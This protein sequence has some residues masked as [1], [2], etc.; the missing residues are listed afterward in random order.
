MTVHKL[1]LRNPKKEKVSFWKLKKTFGDSSSTPY[2]VSY[3]S[4]V[5]RYLISLYDSGIS[6]TSV[7]ISST[8]S[9]V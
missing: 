6:S 5:F 1:V 4:A 7:R 9:I 2:S 8:H 3:S